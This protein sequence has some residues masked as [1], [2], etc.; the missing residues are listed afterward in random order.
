MPLEFESTTHGTFAFGFFNVRSD[1]LLLDNRFFF[2]TA[3]CAMMTELAG[4]DAGSREAALDGW[5]I[6]RPEDVGDLMGAIR[7]R[8]FTGFIGEAYRR[9]PFPSA[10]DDFRQE[11]DGDGTQGE[12]AAMIDKYARRGPIPFE[13]DRTTGRVAIGGVEVTVAV[14]HDLLRY[15]W[16]GGYPRWRDEVRPAYVVA[17]KERLEKSARWPFDGIDWEV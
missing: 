15:V 10:P 12:F 1:M 2:A 13:A 17:M 14:F 4:I 6:E 9:Y 8:R 3:F 11:P 5:I 16:R 7:G